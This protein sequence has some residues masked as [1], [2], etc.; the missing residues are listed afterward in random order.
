MRN[1]QHIPRI[2]ICTA[3]VLICCFAIAQE[4]NDRPLDGRTDESADSAASVEQVKTTILFVRNDKGELLPV[5][6]LTL[7]ELARLKKNDRWTDTSISFT[8]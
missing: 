8:A 4:E 6:D 5:P 7:D 2:S 1:S 3:Y